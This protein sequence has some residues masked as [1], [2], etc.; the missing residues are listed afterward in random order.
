MNWKLP[1]LN[2]IYPTFDFSIMHILMRYYECNGTRK[3]RVKETLQTMGASIFVGGISSLLGVSL[4]A[5]STA[6]V[7]NL[8]FIAVLGLVILGILHGLV[9]LPVILSLIGPE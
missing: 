8:V 1:S 9:F 4:L 2:S 7:L 5:F 3:E 6:E